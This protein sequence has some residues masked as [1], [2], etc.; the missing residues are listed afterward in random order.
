MSRVGMSP[1]VSTPQR[2]SHPIRQAAEET[3]EA[4]EERFN[5]S[6]EK[7]SDQT[8]LKMNWSLLWICFNPSKEK[9]S[10]QTLSGSGR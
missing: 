5:P 7:P 4:V 8:K 9:P 1:L 10:D 2:K 3:E 6:K